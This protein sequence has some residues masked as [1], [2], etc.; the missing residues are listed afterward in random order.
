MKQT[1]KRLAIFTTVIFA[2]QDAQASL[3]MLM[4][5]GAEPDPNAMHFST[6]FSKVPSGKTM[7]GSAS[8][9]SQDGA[10]TLKF[11]AKIGALST[12]KSS[13]ETN[14]F[15]TNETEEKNIR[16]YFPSL[17]ETPGA[18]EVFEHFSGRIIEKVLGADNPGL[19]HEI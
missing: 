13:K 8:F 12:K 3:Q 4:G 15:W 5:G 6:F 16:T 2:T 11:T 10:R 14:P 9:L 19:L 7:E 17:D 1:L 18:D